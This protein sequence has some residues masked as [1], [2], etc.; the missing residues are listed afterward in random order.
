[1][2]TVVVVVVAHEVRK[3]RAPSIDFQ[4]CCCC[5]LY[6]ENMEGAA[7]HSLNDVADSAAVDEEGHRGVSRRRLHSLMMMMWDDDD[8]FVVDHRLCCCWK[9]MDGGRSFLPSQKLLL[10]I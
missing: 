8:F 6:N 7:A 4:G 9:E 10:I 3:R 1:M 5:D 2:W